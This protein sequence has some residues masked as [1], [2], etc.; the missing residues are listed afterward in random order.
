MDEVSRVRMSVACY[1]PNRDPCDLLVH[2]LAVYGMNGMN[3][4]NAECR[5]L[6]HHDIMFGFMLLVLTAMWLYGWCG[7]KRL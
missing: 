5:S 4:M 2:R 6:K 3:G 7:S 1:L